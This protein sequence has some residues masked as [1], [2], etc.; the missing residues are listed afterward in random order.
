MM[1]RGERRAFRAIERMS[2]FQQV[3][4][5]IDHVLYQRDARELVSEIVTDDTLGAYAPRQVSA[6]S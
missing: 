2:G 4:V 5:S 6:G 1:W 3:V